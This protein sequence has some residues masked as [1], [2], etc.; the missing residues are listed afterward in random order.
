MQCLLHALH[1]QFEALQI[2]G[3]KNIILI[4]YS[5]KDIKSVYD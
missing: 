1:T 4:L 3:K 5:L 2:D